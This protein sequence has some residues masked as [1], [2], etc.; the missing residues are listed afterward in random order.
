[1]RVEFHGGPYDGL[2]L[3]DAQIRR[4]TCSLRVR[5]YDGIRLFFLLPRPTD[6]DAVFA[7]EI[8]PTE[9][10]V[11]PYELIPAPAAESGAK[12]QDA[13]EN[14]A[15]GRAVREGRIE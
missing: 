15:F 9:S 6:W 4:C 14:G 13:A 3:S 11:Y 7:G 10:G 2:R 12:F 5:T 1:M 8:C